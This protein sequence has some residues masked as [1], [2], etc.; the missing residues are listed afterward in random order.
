GLL[1]I[2]FI[3]PDDPRN[4]EEVYNWIVL[5]SVISLLAFVFWMIY[6]MRFNV[7]KRFGEWKKLDTVKTF[8]LYFLVIL[9]IV[10]WPFIPPIVQSI[11]ADNKY[12]AAELINDVNAM[13]VKLCQLEKDSVNKRFSSDTLQLKNN[14]NGL[15]ERTISDTDAG[16]VSN[17]S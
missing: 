9:I 11:R 15:V 10:S 4:P 2:S 14:L 16:E 13:N 17:N 1:L 12:S 5:I 6:L 3:V 8:L 7:F